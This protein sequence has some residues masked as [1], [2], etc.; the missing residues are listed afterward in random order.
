MRLC[1][2]NIMYNEL[3]EQCQFILKS[4]TTTESSRYIKFNKYRDQFRLSNVVFQSFPIGSICSIIALFIYVCY[5]N[6][7]QFKD[8][9]SAIKKN[10]NFLRT[11][12][13][14][15]DKMSFQRFFLPKQ[16]II[17][18]RK[19]HRRWEDV[20]TFPIT[21]HNNMSILYF[22]FIIH[23][24]EFFNFNKSTIIY[25][26]SYIIKFLIIFATYLCDYKLIHWHI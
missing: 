5:E 24:C 17:P 13:M 26:N 18:S 6:M 9:V 14:V 4:K 19:R 25:N 10:N 12:D 2:L 15:V 1:M 7:K 22:Y 8:K 11:I 16:N 21:C 20:L 23:L 3:Y